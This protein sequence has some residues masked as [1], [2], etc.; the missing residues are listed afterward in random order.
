MLF[1]PECRK[2]PDMSPVS[3]E[4]LRKTVAELGVPQV[5]RASGLKSSTLHDFVNGATKSLSVANMQR[6][7]TAI[8][9]LRQE[10]SPD[11]AEPLPANMAK[12]GGLEVAGDTYT[13][14]PVYELSAS[15][16]AGALT[17]DN[18]PVAHQ[19]FREGE[20][21]SITKA[22]YDQL[23]IIRVS[24]D[25]MWETLHEGD[26]VLVDMSVER[27]KRDGI[28]ILQIEDELMIKRCQV[29]LNDGSILVRSD[30]Q[31]YPPIK[32]KADRLRILGRVVWMARALG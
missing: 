15:A 9:T 22:A 31:A 18:L 11:A 32:V 21:R 19:I 13:P 3:I 14:I 27:V 29:D 26:R 7:E 2:Q 5:M 6:L 30:N 20:L 28:Y 23:S 24:G 17:E 4:A 10:T 12:R 16:G 25:S 8:R 1:L